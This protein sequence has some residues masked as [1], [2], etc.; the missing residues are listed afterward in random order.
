MTMNRIKQAFAIEMTAA[1]NAFARQDFALAFHHLERAH[2]LGQRSFSRHW[3]SHWWMLKVGLK[4]R[5]PRE[6]AGQI[7]RLIA[8]V[9]GF[10]LGWIPLGNTGGANVSAVRP[11]PMPDDLATT[12]GPVNIWADVAL[13]LVLLAA[14]FAAIGFL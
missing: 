13:R 12:L 10:V 1:R 3:I 4:T 9:P 5:D 7:L 8:V 11:M 6:I 14:V 2:I